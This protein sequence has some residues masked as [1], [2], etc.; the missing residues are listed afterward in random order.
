MKKEY[1]KIDME[2]VRKTV[3]DKGYYFIRADRLFDDH[4]VGPRLYIV[5]DDSHIIARHPEFAGMAILSLSRFEPIAQAV[6]EYLNNEDRERHRA[7]NLVSLEMSEP[8]NNDV[9]QDEFE[10]FRYELDEALK[11]LTDVQ[12]K[13]VYLY[14]YKGLSEREIAAIEG[15]SYKQVRKSLVQ[16]QKKLK[17]YF[18]V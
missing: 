18:S 14:Y 4:F 8:R 6:N 13:R 1:L 5:T 17:K 15:V 16:A 3:K 11:T 2:L 9:R 7:E 12:R 10:L